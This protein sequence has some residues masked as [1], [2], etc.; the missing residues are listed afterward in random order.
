MKIIFQEMIIHRDGH[1][2]NV[3]AHGVQ[4]ACHGYTSNSMLMLI[5]AF[6]L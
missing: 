1:E 3:D 5:G 4:Y 6:G 2:K